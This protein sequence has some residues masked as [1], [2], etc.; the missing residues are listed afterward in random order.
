[1]VDPRLNS[2]HLDDQRREQFRQARDVLLGARGEETRLAEIRRLGAGEGDS[3][4]V[5][6][7]M[8]DR[9]PPES[10]FALV[11]KDGTY[12]LKAGVNTIGRLPDNDVVLHDPFV[13]R[14]H[15]AVLVHA[16]R[17]CELYDVASK[18]GTFLNGRRLTGPTPLHPGDEIRM[19]DRQLVFL[20]KGDGA[21]AAASP[22][23][24]QAE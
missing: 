21:A 11:D 3:H 10:A 23:H 24:T 2:I 5:A 12:P 9:L 8:E 14:R 20:S 6:E 4:T 16:G 13:S 18:N 22:T 15:C 1:M 17:A 19:C 7:G